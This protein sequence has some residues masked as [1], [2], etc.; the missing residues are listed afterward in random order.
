MKPITSKMLCLLMAMVM[1][2]SFSACTEDTVTEQD[3]E[4]T[5]GVILP[6]ETKRELS[7]EKARLSIAFT[8]EAGYTL[9]YDNKDMIKSITPLQ[10]SEAGSHIATVEV[11]PNSSESNRS[12][13]IYI[14]VDGF[15]RTTLVELNQ[16]SKAQDM[17]EIA[18]YL[19]E[20][21]KTEYYWLDEYNAKW[22][23]FDFKVDRKT[24]TEYNN[25]L[26]RNLLKMTTNLADGGTES[27]GSRYL[28]TNAMV[29]P[30]SDM[31]DTTRSDEDQPTEEG[32][33]FDIT[34][35]LLII[36]EENGVRLFAF[37]VQH[38]YNS[39]PAASSGL[40][41]SDLITKVNNTDIT[42]NNVNEIYAKLLMQNDPSI[43]L[44]KMDFGTEKYATITISRGE[45]VASPVAYYTILPEHERF[46][47][48]GKK[49]GY[50]SF[51]SFDYTYDQ[52]LV[53]ALQDLVSQ[54][55]EEF[56]LDLRYNGGGAVDTAAILTSMILDESYVGQICAKL[57]RN[58]KN[59]RKSEEILIQK[60]ISD[61]KNVD[62]PNLNI[63]RVYVL[64]S[65]FT[66]SASEMVITGLEGLDFEV[67]TIGERT[68][69][70]NCGMD[71]IAKNIGAYYCE[72]APITFLCCNAKD[73]N[74]YADG[75]VPDIDFDDY[76][77][78][79]EY[80]RLKTQL[81]LYPIPIGAWG[82]MDYDLALTEAVSNIHG[83]TL[84]TPDTGEGESEGEGEGE[85]GQGGDDQTTTRSTS[86]FQIIKGKKM[87]DNIKDWKQRGMFKIIE[88]ESLNNEETQE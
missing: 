40:R 64:V 18:M 29:I 19:D 59:P 38:V 48:E 30:L 9:S 10:G 84:L 53:D 25:M 86:K 66:A 42:D 70:K 28:Y 50:L 22:A 45:Y 3:R 12:A 2:I 63:N 31:E 13:I 73:F 56:I 61:E 85:G 5:E 20:R 17:D 75:L 16:K 57:V 79:A 11:N 72:F 47:K 35:I 26:E 82:N 67:I 68:E 55:A 62:L 58:P 37:S 78:K 1:L 83:S 39:S 76:R 52:M 36:S 4:N 41:R 6:A 44:E 80:E 34:P 87:T 88:Q 60:Y 27:D 54:G 49:I 15:A 51:L 24:S 77:G 74:D 71:V 43:T 21:L 81:E 33:G 14:T 65:S 8:T 7:A 32:Y 23:T 69:G 46:N